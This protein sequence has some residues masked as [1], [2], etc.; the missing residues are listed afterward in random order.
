MRKNR[1]GSINIEMINIESLRIGNSVINNNS[2]LGTVLLII[3]TSRVYCALLE[4]FEKVVK[5]KTRLF[6]R[7]RGIAELCRK[8][9]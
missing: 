4:N 9:T 2:E 7:P 5:R 3:I 8:A 6:Y 1:K